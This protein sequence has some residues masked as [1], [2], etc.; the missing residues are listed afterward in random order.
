MWFKVDDKLHVNR[1]TRRILK[2]HTTKRI[3]AAPMGL[4]VLAGA[5]AGQNE[6]A[7]GWVPEY[8]LDRWDDNWQDLVVRLVDADFWWPESRDGEPG[9]SFVNWEEYK[10]GGGAS[11]DGKRGNHNRWHVKRG[12]VSPTCEHCPREPDIAS[13]S[14]PDDPEVIHR[15]R[16]DI[17]AMIAPE[18]DHLSGHIANPTRTRPE[19]DPNPTRKSA[20]PEPVDNLPVLVADNSAPAKADTPPKKGSRIIEN[21][22]PTRTAANTT[23]EEGHDTG[24]LSLELARFR[25]YWAAVPGAKGVKLDWDATWRNWIRRAKD[26]EP[27]KR[28][29]TLGTTDWETPNLPAPKPE[30]QPTK[31]PGGQHDQPVLPRRF[32]GLVPWGQPRRVA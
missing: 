32:R 6:S 24:W 1:K 25:D 17:G 19:P 10:P 13:E 28:Q 27:A 30:T 29:A 3:D 2:S 22:N 14:E 8:E 15:Y 23:A 18:S 31:K 21:W 26:F 16:G 7:T 11:D 20:R 12:V 4:W 5:W 9:Y